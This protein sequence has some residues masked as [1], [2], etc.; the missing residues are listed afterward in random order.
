VGDGGE[1]SRIE[2]PEIGLSVVHARVEAIPDNAI[3]PDWL[4]GALAQPS[5][6]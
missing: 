2:Y 1:R 5:T 4:K 6:A 3:I